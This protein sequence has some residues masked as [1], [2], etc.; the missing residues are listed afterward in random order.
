MILKLYITGLTIPEREEVLKQLNLIRDKVYPEL[1]IDYS[2]L[3]HSPNSIIINQEIED[4]GKA[5]FLL[6][7]IQS[8]HINHMHDDYYGIYEDVKLHASLEY[9]REWK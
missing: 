2:L 6:E 4:I 9:D 5:A 1:D 8:L 3:K 7:C